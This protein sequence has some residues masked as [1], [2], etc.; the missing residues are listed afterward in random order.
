[1]IGYG[2]TYD[3]QH[4]DAF[5]LTVENT[6]HTLTPPLNTQM[7]TVPKRPGAWYFRTD[8][9][10]RVIQVDIVLKSDSLINFR[11]DVRAI[12]GWLDPSQGPR[13]LIFD[14]EPDKTYQAVLY[15]NGGDPP[16]ITQMVLL[17][18]TSLY[19]MCPDPYAYDAMEQTV[20]ISSGTTSEAITNDNTETQPI[21]TVTFSTTAS[22]F[23]ITKQET[24]EYV[25]VIYNFAANDQLVIDCDKGL[26]TINGINQMN[27]LDI[28]SDFFSLSNGTNTLEIDNANLGQTVVV[29]TPRYL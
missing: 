9:G 6:F 29:Y 2:F 23:K 27:A 3:D 12:S 7:L 14:N 13:S 1:M 8:Y 25:N 10:P 22:S 17:G 16:N 19:F 11:P 5:N 28:N 24:G 18:K 15:T 21:I 20:T 4:T 26:V